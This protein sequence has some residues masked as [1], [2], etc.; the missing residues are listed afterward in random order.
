LRQIT[1]SRQTD[2]KFCDFC[3][4]R[5]VSRLFTKCHHCHGLENPA[6]VLG[7]GLCV[8]NIH[9]KIIIPSATGSSC[10]RF[11]GLKFVGFFINPLRPTVHI[12]LIDLD[13]MSVMIFD[14][15]Y[16]LLC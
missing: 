5:N 14:N 13:S 2:K 12:H 6:H 10:K 9:F 11:S 1:N 7:P 3:E 4:N 8:F 16:S 15:L